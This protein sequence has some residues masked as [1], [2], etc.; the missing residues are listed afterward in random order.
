MKRKL[1]LFLMII[2]VSLIFTTAAICNQCSAA[3]SQN[4]K[5]DVADNTDNQ[6]TSVETTAGTGETTITGESE[7][8]TI[9][10]QVYMGPE[11]NAAD[12]VCFYRVEA[13]VTGNPMPTE[14]VFSRD[15]SN[16]AWGSLRAQVNLTRDDP[17]YTLT[18]SVTTSAGTD[19][20]SY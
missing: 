2:L 18:A 6:T 10:L 5:E 8:P 17:D 16:K 7:A 14:A 11:Y 20:D 3:N 13:I 4:T 19:E 9:E 15:N 12:D 1:F